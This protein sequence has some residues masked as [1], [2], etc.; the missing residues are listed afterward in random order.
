M[1]AKEADK[2]SQSCSPQKKMGKNIESVPMR[3]NSVSEYFFIFT[4][5][6]RLFACHKGNSFNV[7]YICLIYLFGVEIGDT[8]AKSEVQ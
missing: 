6:F 3:S 8:I 7:T 2:T 5:A 4:F 1:S